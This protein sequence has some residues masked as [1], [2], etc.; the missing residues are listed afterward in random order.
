MARTPPAARASTTAL[1]FAG[2]CDRMT[3]T[4]PQASMVLTVSDRVF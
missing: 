3:A 4:T 1:N 2:S